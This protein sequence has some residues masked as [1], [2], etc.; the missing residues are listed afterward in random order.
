MRNRTTGREL[1]LKFLF[2]LDLRGPEVRAELAEFLA[3]SQAPEEARQFAAELVNGYLEEADRID[4]EVGEAAEN[5]ELKRMATVDRNILR[6]STYELT[7]RPET[8][9]KVVIN[10]AIEIGKKFGSAR[11]ASFINGILDRIRRSRDRAP[12]RKADPDT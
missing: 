10:E 1:A 5:W 2:M 6:I 7:A 8:P 12:R 4:A 9:A 3:A 11:S